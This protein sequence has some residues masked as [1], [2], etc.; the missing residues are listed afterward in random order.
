MTARAT[1]KA[2][3]DTIRTR[4]LTLRPPVPDDDDFLY[5]LHSDPALYGL[6]PWARVTDREELEAMTAAWRATW[7]EHG[8]G[9]FVADD[10]DTGEPLGLAGVRP[11]DPGRLNL[12]YRFAAAAQGR[13]LGRESAR[14]VVVF[15]AEWLP[16]HVVEA[17]IRP[18][19][20]A[21][22]RTAEAA[23][24][25][26]V[27]EISHAGDPAEA[28]VSLLLE[29][30]RAGRVDEIGPTDR[31]EL[32]DLWQAVTE[33]GGAVGFLPGAPRDRIAQALAEHEADMRAGRSFAVGLRDPD[34]SLVGWGWWVSPAN[35]LL[36]HRRWLYRFMVDP[37]RQGR[38]LGA[39]L[40]ASMIGT[41]RED[42]GE[43]LGL[44]YRSG[45]GVGDFYARQG[46][47]EVGRIPGGIRVGAGDDRDDVEMV[48]RA[49]GSPLVADGRR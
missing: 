30:P 16:D 38:N 13:G 18:G 35:P 14:A 33:A 42:G 8:F 47:V 45:T 21:S 29:A 37:R 39:I 48:R 4:H 19:H 5:A 24:L 40:L 6:A 31:E 34:A 28:G 2:M 26:S 10:A 22:I 11:A 27:G 44:D 43:L 25:L 32:L 23:G 41:A 1:P 46:F 7:Q 3:P 20:E 9:Y 17:V 49:D 36:A 15:A 12:A